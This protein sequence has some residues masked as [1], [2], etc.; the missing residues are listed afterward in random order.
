LLDRGGVSRLLQ[1]V[2][3]L[4]AV[5]RA[6]LTVFLLAQATSNEHFGRGGNQF[7][8]YGCAGSVDASP[9]SRVCLPGTC[10]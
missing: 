4:M 5:F 9:R 8:L 2:G 6:G 10:L 7:F 3:W 1:L